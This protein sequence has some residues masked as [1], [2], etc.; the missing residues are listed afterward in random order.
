MPINNF[1]LKKEIAVFTKKIISLLLVVLF[2]AG[3]ATGPRKGIEATKKS[4]RYEDTETLVMLD[5]KLR[6]QLY[7][8]DQSPT[9]SEDGRLIARANFLNKAKDT[10]ELQLQ[11]VFKDEAGYPT[12]ETNWESV[13]VPG[14]S[15]YYYQ[16]SSLNN[17]SSTYTIRCRPVK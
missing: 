16:A 13:L 11:T 15:H 17:K 7:V 8:T 2:L 14:N 3:C 10:L 6:K 4:E 1:I 12:D 5:N 9:W